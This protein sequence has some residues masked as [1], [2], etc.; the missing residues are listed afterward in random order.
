M[1]DYLFVT[2]DG[3]GNVPPALALARRILDRGHRVRVLGHP[4][5]RTSV[6]GTGLEFHPF[7]T[8]PAFTGAEPHSVLDMVRLF[9]DSRLEDDVATEC[10]RAST[11]V[12]V[13]DCLLLP[14][15]RACARLGVPFVNLEH[16]F[17]GYLRR[18]W[19]R[20]PLGL[21][22]RLKGIPARRQWDAARLTLV[23]C[24]PGLD[25]GY[26]A[27]RPGNRVWTGPFVDATQPRD[28]TGQEPSVLVSLS[29]FSYP[30][31]QDAL[32]RVV[33][34]VGLLDVPVV[35]TTGPVLDPSA[36][37][38]PSHV[39]VH[40]FVPHDRLMPEA[41]LV[42]GHGGHATTM[43]ALGHELPLVVLPMHPMLDQ[44]MVGKRV[45]RAG[46]GRVLSKKAPTGQVREA[47][48]QLM[49]DGPHRTAAAHLGAEIR[50]A[51]G[52]TRAAELLEQ[53]DDRPAGQ[54]RE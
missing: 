18:G 19:D 49:V 34:A 17:D 37:R 54:L 16:C 31:M 50:A 28:R 20:G 9:T 12:V 27:V 43:R 2:W 38:A 42:V 15:L 6:E 41:S 40:R 23:A 3:G 1:S 51:D 10:R 44:P 29:T 48:A 36:L 7:A 47:V 24:L 30:G 46:A 53:L 13:V 5:Q 32:Q 4:A 26:D 22:A 21:A 8:V 52:L 35:V 25:P 33:D 11:D 45:E 14:A 39:E